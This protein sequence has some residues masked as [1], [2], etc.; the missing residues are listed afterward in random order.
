MR[1]R[2]L[3]LAFAGLGLA[4]FLLFAGNLAFVRGQG[5]SANQNNYPGAGT[6][7]SLISTSTP[8]PS[9]GVIRLGPTDTIA[10]ANNAANHT[11]TLTTDGFDTFII[12]GNFATIAFGQAQKATMSVGPGGSGQFTRYGIN[13]VN[14]AG[15]GVVPIYAATSQKTES[16][17][18]ANVLTYTPPAAAGTYRLLLTGSISAASAATLGWTA[19]WTDS[20]GNA[21]APTNLPV[22]LASTGV[23]GATTGALSAVDRFSGS[24]PIDI[25]NSAT[26]I[27]IKLTFSGTSFT[28]KVSATVEELI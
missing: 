9:S 15:L 7:S 23:C 3:S 22:C 28:A 4:A 11:D 8:L 2:T 12:G 26:N 16:A 27:V 25:N 20:N 1:N 5:G 13:A 19:T 24:F 10:W 18:D 21:A 6:P 17:A 14:T